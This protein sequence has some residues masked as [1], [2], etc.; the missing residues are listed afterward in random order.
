[1]SI[2]Y[3]SGHFPGLEALSC[4]NYFHFEAHIHSGYVIWLNSEGAEHFTIQKKKNQLLPGSISII[5]PGVVHSNCPAE[6][7][8]RHLKSLYLEQEFLLSADRL[9]EGCFATHTELPSMVAR[10]PFLCRT[11]QDFHEAILHGD[12]QLSVDQCAIAFFSCLAE[13]TGQGKFDGE[14]HDG[15]GRRLKTVIDYMHD[16]LE[17]QLR[18]EELAGVAECTSYHIIRL[19]NSRLGLSP[20]AYLLQLRLEKAF[21]LLSQGIPI[22]DAALVSGFSDQSHLT[23]KF[24]KR[25]GLTPGHYR[26]QISF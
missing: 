25:Y 23:R 17:K 11:F 1:M 8:G 4:E 20:H 12:E 7:A 24:K 15:Y 22:A 10:D 5:E 19:F 21:S 2:V 6:G 13:T 18:L 16:N 26:A 3:S 9:L 14:K